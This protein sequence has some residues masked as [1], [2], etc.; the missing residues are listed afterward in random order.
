MLKLGGVCGN[1]KTFEIPLKI[2][3]IKNKKIICKK[4][5]QKMT[6]NPSKTKSWVRF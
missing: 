6:S 4:A 5:L 3:K 1:P 2:K